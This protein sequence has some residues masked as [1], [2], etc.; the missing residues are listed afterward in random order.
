M[1]LI[2]DEPRGYAVPY[3]TPAIRHFQAPQTLENRHFPATLKHLI[4]GPGRRNEKKQHEAEKL[5]TPASR[6]FNFILKNEIRLCRDSGGKQFHKVK[7]F[8][9]PVFLPVFRRFK[10]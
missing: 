2:R 9:L 10:L 1:I 6:F 5:L 4:H 3:S 8:Y 7:L